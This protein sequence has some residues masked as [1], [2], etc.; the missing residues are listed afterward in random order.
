MKV[1]TRFGVLVASMTLCGAALVGCGSDPAPTPPAPSTYHVVC[2]S[3]AAK[4]TV[5]GLAESYA[6][7]ANVA[8]TITENDPTNYKVT[9]V[10]SSQVTV[11]TVSTLSYSFTM[12]ET[13]VSLT[14]GTKEVDKY[15]VT[16]STDDI[17]VNSPVTFLL[18]LGETEVVNVVI[19]ADASEEK[20][21]TIDENEVTFKEEG[22][23]VLKFRDGD[24]G[25]DVP[26]SF[27][28]HARNTVHGE[29]EDDPLT[30]AEAIAIG[31][32]LDITWNEKVDGQTV[33]HYGGI[34]E[35]KY[36]IED[37][38][39]SVKE[40][41]EADYD[42][43]KNVTFNFGEFQAYQ[44]QWKD[45]TG[46]EIIKSIQVG[47]TVKVHTKIMNF[48]G[49]TTAKEKGTVETYKLAPEYPSIVK[50]DNETLQEITLSQTELRMTV[51]DPD[52]TLTATLLPDTGAA[53]SWRS[54]DENIAT[55]ANG[56]VHAV[57]NGETTV[58]AEAGGKSAE[59]AVIV[60]STKQVYRM[61]AADELSE[62]E[63]YV[64]GALDKDGMAYA[65]DDVAATYYVATTRNIAEASEVKV[66]KVEDKFKLKL[67]NSYL[68]YQWSEG[69]H[70]I[71]RESDASSEKIVEFEFDA[72]TF[73][74]HF[75][76]GDDAHTDLYLNF[77][78]NNMSYTKATNSNP[79]FAIWG[80][81]EPVAVTS[82]ALSE[83]ELSLYPE[84]SAKLT[85][86]I[87]PLNASCEEVTFASS[88]A[89][90]TVSENGEVT[91]VSVGSANVTVT[92][93]G[94]VSAP[95]VVTVNEVPSG[96]V[97]K[98]FDVTTYGEENKCTSGSSKMAATTAI[99]DVA[100]F[101]IA[102]TDSNSGKLYK[103]NQTQKW[104]FRLYKSGGASVTIKLAEGYTLV[105]AVINVK[106]SNT[107]SELYE[108]G[109][110][111]S[112]TV[113]NNQAVYQNA[114]Y[115]SAVYYI[116]VQYAVVNA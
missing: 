75:A 31:H 37:V 53:V 39:T 9:G 54:D 5:N 61:L 65:K 51:G 112:L 106:T 109:T 77:Y 85:F 57:A 42:K 63:T 96:V 72:N 17:I 86:T 43:Y 55:V 15:S 30:A 115:N 46:W 23:F 52:I 40:Q 44:I 89:S 59:C 76:G 8:F 4:Y 104:A 108:L 95:C 81:A 62:T 34:S 90:V 7:G 100:S 19:T 71:L 67:G 110:D 66:F 56:V 35:V 70:N 48:G 58:Y 12:P 102:G 14:V 73:R 94:V 111:V 38:V 92:V 13:D 80:Y 29:T 74:F 103:G 16:A 82:V 78:S 41:S 49:K 50:V 20:E 6:A 84:D 97:T 26:G 114:D 68:G 3:D 33:W 105:S 11:T 24:R 22:D 32:G 93:D 45:K 69:H 27:T 116:T 113:A 18:K 64:L 60:S 98:T 2:T 10:T 25:V 91:A 83:S 1:K 28:F 101:T 36:Y 21:L 87:S 79:Q 99:D 107:S 47:S 88:D